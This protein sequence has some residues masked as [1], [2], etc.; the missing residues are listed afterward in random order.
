[1]HEC[2]ANA[3]PNE[4][5][6]GHKRLEKL[7]QGPKVS[8]GKLWT[9]D[10]TNHLTKRLKLAPIKRFGKDVSILT[11]SRDILKNN[12]F[13]FNKIPNKVISNLYMFGPRILYQIL[14]DIN[15]TRVITIQNHSIL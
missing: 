14:K 9:S 6:F 7:A 12:N 15:N 3:N 2:N 4:K 13:P 10:N 5:Y 1:M 8:K 11:I